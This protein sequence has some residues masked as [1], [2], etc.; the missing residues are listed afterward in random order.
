MARI[1]FLSL[2]VALCTPAALFAQGSAAKSDAAQGTA[3]AQG[4]T[5]KATLKTGDGKDAGTARLEDTPHGVLIHVSL[6]NVS[7]GEHAIHIHATGKCEGPA[8][9]SAGGHFNPGGAHHGIMN[10]QGPHAGDLPNLY[11]PESGKLAEDLFAIGV[12][13]ESGKPNSLLDQDGSALVVHA[14]ADDNKSDP[15]G[16]SGDRVAC[17]VIQ[18]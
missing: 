1:R 15:S 13:L 2:V 10:A 5:A 9:T 3:A 17:G 11:V 12:T 4:A 14:K 8:F 18:K 16:N 6:Q 7:P